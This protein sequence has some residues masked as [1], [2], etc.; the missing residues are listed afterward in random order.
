[1]NKHEEYA[2]GIEFQ[3]IELLNK[4]IEAAD[5][6]AR[7]LQDATREA[8]GTIK[9][10]EEARKTLDRERAAVVASVTYRV[11]ELIEQA[12][13]RELGVM[14]KVIEE[15]MH[16]NVRKVISEFDRLEKILLGK[17]PGDSGKSIREYIRELES[18]FKVSYDQLMYA[19]TYAQVSQ[20]KL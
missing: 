15:Q 3:A 10:V 20:E 12:V 1:M 2:P 7:K 6:A 16:V 11:G 19:L 8:N 4:R 9:A 18:V 5:T 13:N 17:E 14:G